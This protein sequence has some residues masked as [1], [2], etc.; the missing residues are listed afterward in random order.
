MRRR[1][2]QR[3]KGRLKK[4]IPSATNFSPSVLQERHRP[5]SRRVILRT[6]HRPDAPAPLPTPQAGA[7]QAYRR[8]SKERS[9]DHC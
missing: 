5:T 8:R 2:A 7:G 1:V 6:A 4:R 9:L 3:I